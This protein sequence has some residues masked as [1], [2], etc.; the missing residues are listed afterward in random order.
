LKDFFV[1]SAFFQDTNQVFSTSV[2]ML[3]LAVCDVEC[4]EIEKNIQKHPIVPSSNQN[5]QPDNSSSSK[6]KVTYKNYI[7]KEKIAIQALINFARY[8][9]WDK[10]TLILESA[11]ESFERFIKASE[12]GAKCNEKGKMFEILCFANLVASYKNKGIVLYNV[13]FIPEEKKE[14]WMK[15]V[16]F[17]VNGFGTTEKLFGITFEQYFQNVVTLLEDQ[18]ND[19]LDKYMNY[20]VMPPN[21][22][23]P[24]GI[25]ISKA[26]GK[27]Y[28]ILFSCKCYTSPLD[29]RSSHCSTMIDRLYLD[30]YT[31]NDPFNVKTKKG[32][33]KQNR[34]RGRW[35]KFVKAFGLEKGKESII[36]AVLRI[37]IHAATQYQQYSEQIPPLKD[38]ILPPTTSIDIDLKSL[39]HILDPT[40]Y[41][42]VVSILTSSL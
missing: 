41:N 17:I 29:V 6:E 40:S 30:H 28:F 24:D 23:H 34:G 27:L 12:T 4:I 13:E 39:K 16:N 19:Q 37:H 9:K 25:W 3:E 7:L 32:K 5:V 11:I 31:E 33:I 18:N 10:E 38:I 42:A 15:K 21:Q 35:E 20:I 1:Y 2:D 14:G 8:S 26:E 36:G 22:V